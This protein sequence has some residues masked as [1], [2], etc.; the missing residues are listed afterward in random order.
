MFSYPQSSQAFTQV[1]HIVMMMMMMMTDD[2]V[3]N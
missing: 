1:P 2:D 3:V